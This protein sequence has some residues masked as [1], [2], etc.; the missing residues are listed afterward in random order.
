VKLD[1]RAHATGSG[2]SQV[3]IDTH[4]NA[5]LEAFSDGVFAIAL[6]L[7]IIDIKVPD[8]E[9][10]RGNTELSRALIRLAPSVL[11]F[12]L[13][14]AVVLITWVNHHV[15]LELLRTSSA[16]FFYANGFLLLTVV[17][18]PFP[19]SLLGAFVWT[20]HAAPA[21]VLYD[22]V[23]AVQALAWLLVF[24]TAIENRLPVNEHATS[25]MRAQKQSSYY[26]VALYGT[27]AL[28]A[29]WL[30]VTAAAVTTATWIFWLALSIRMKTRRSAE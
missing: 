6:T 4:A 30:P 14:F 27:L 16:A 10:I 23:L 17:F 8:M 18:L 5:R 7:L 29:V 21:V 24:H 9:A 3:T 1:R 11:A 20:D 19:T 28:T 13:S 2:A 15:L 26:A 25:V 12:L 22:A